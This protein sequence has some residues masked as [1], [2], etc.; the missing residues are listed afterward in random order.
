VAPYLKAFVQTNHG[1]RMHLV[2]L[3]ASALVSPRDILALTLLLDWN[4]RRFELRVR[5]VVLEAKGRSQRHSLRSV[6]FLFS[7]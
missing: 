7:S 6:G 3:I 5:Y 2:S 4:R 1:Q